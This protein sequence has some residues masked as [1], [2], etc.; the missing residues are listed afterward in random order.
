M[1]KTDNVVNVLDMI[2]EDMR[3]DATEFDGQPFDGKTVG[4]YFGNHGAA[5]AT[6]ASI[7][8]VILEHTEESN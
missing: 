4:T 8:K 3:N 5:I 6:L 1:K 2:I 7:I